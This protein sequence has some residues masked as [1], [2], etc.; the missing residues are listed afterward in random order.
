MR[1]AAIVVLMLFVTVPVFGDQ[2]APESKLRARFGALPPGQ[3]A[4]PYANLFRAQDLLKKADAEQR[5]S[6]PKVVCG[7]TIIPADP[8]ID[9]KMGITPKKD[10]LEFKIRAIEPTVCKTGQ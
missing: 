5:A 6:K 9:P 4:D 7:M 3:G 1:T 10:G 2:P 8:K